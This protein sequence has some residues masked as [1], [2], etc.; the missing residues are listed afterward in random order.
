MAMD[1][2]YFSTVDWFKSSDAFFMEEFTF[3]KNDA[4]FIET[5]ACGEVN[6]HTNFDMSLVRLFIENGNVDC[7]VN[8]ETAPKFKILAKMIKD[9]DFDSGFIDMIDNPGFMKDGHFSTYV[10]KAFKYKEN[11]A[12]KV[13]SMM[14]DILDMADVAHQ[15]A[16]YYYL[17]DIDG[18]YPIRT[19]CR[20]F[21]DS[22]PAFAEATKCIVDSDPEYYATHP[23]DKDMLACIAVAIIVSDSTFLNNLPMPNATISRVANCFPE[24][25]CLSFAKVAMH[26]SKYDP[27][28][29]NIDDISDEQDKRLFKKYRFVNGDEIKFTPYVS[30]EEFYVFLDAVLRVFVVDDVV[31]SCSG[32]YRSFS[33]FLA[34][35]RHCNVDFMRF[36]DSKKLLILGDYF[37][38][39]EPADIPYMKDI[40]HFMKKVPDEESVLTKIIPNAGHDAEDKKVPDNSDN[41]LKC[42]HAYKIDATTGEAEEINVKDLDNMKLSGS[43]ASILGTLLNPDKYGIWGD[44]AAMCTDKLEDYDPDLE[45][46]DDDDDDYDDEY[47]DEFEDEEDDDNE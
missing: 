8:T 12:D 29:T 20:D 6:L 28:T 18:T 15:A 26:L 39:F 24:E 25:Y 17:E 21:F 36:S 34:M 1:K 7:R 43:A 30:D 44:L 42:L 47:E 11:E 4:S 45:D 32:P 35:M 10:G 37:K 46:I 33:N 27:K 9:Q 31:G 14:L 19:K 41:R 40:E 23:D 5:N 13:L 22:L 16:R 3:R 38:S 2:N